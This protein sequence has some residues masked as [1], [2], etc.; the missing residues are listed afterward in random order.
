VRP[1]TQGGAAW[2]TTLMQ[3]TSYLNQLGSPWV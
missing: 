2:T 1:C 3:W